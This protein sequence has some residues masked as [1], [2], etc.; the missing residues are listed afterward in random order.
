MKINS[1][2]FLMCLFLICSLTSFCQ[3]KKDSKIIVTLVDTSGLFEKVAKV[4]L[5]NDY[6]LET[7]DRES[8]FITTKDKD[9]KKYAFKNKIRVQI[10]DSCLILTAKER[11]AFKSIMG[12]TYM[13]VSFIGA[14][15]SP[16]REAW[17]D[18]DS[19]AKQLGTVTYSK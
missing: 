4:L 1:N 8:G 12:D 2:L 16:M 19:I 3:E 15:N 13:D 6:D 9:L 5:E 7:K 18:M 14:K 17:N 10:K 11:A